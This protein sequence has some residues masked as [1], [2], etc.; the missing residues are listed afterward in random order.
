[1]EFVLS[2][3]CDHTRK[4]M[5]PVPVP[6]VVTRIVYV[7]RPEDSEGRRVFGWL[8]WREL[9]DG[10][11]GALQTYYGEARRLGRIGTGI[12]TNEL[13]PGMTEGQRW[14]FW[15]SDCHDTLPARH[16]SV[17]RVFDGLRRAGVSSVTLTGLGARLS[18]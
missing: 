1:M 16:S 6:R 7:P 11:P 14:R 3:V 15:C 10:H 5:S 12:A 4:P 13:V 2:V 9:D 18:G 8:E 17:V